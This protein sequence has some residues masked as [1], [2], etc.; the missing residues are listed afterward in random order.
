VILTTERAIPFADG[1]PAGADVPQLGDR[2]T[3]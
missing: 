2:S 1:T 3:P